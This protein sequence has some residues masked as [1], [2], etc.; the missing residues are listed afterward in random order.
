MDPGIIRNVPA[1][2][3]VLQQAN[4]FGGYTDRIE[5]SFSKLRAIL[6]HI[7]TKRIG[8]VV[9]P[10]C[11][12]NCI[13]SGLSMNFEIRNAYASAHRINVWARA[14]V[15][16]FCDFIERYQCGAEA[17]C[18]HYSLNNIFFNKKHQR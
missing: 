9:A 17:G 10:R 5:V 15:G 7:R 6:L 8:T 1:W 12:L 13:F 14:G 3:N 16:V 18:L 2:T 4:S 11:Y